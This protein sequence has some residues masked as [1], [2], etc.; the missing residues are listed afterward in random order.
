LL[1]NIK[2]E[3]KK[4]ILAFIFWLLIFIILLILLVI[5]LSYHYNFILN[6][7]QNFSTEIYFGNKLINFKYIKKKNKQISYI[8]F[9]GYEKEIIKNKKSSKKEE[10][11]KKNVEKA[12]KEKKKS[13]SSF[14]FKLINKTNIIHVFKF[15][16]KIYKEI[17]PDS[18]NIDLAIAFSDPYYN[19]L[20]LANYYSLKGVYPKFPVSITTYWDREVIEGRGE[21]KGKIKPIVI[22]FLI[23]S[24]VFSFNTLK[25]FWQY[26]KN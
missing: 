7:E 18:I 20:I 2:K 12:D 21:I 8:K 1:Y 17:K 16:F 14:P 9:L 19:G 11:I 15:L 5:S 26:R 3:E 6:Y 22:L 23:F 24:F 4:L 25:M 10:I 13:K